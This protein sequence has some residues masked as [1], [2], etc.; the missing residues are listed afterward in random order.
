[1]ETGLFKRVGIVAKP[2][3]PEARDVL[4]QLITWLKAKDREVVLDV[5]TAALAGAEETGIAKADLPRM[6]DLVVVLGG[7]GTLLSVARLV[8]SGEVPILGVNLGGLGFLTEITLDELYPILGLVL[9]GKYRGSRRMLL[10]VSVQRGGESIAEHVVL[11][12]AVMTKG[13][14]AR[15]VDLAVFVEQEYVTTYRAD[16]LIVCTPTGS[17]AYGLSAG[18]PI[19]FPSMRAIILVPICPHTLTD[20][21]LVLPEEVRVQVALESQDEDVYLTLD[22][23]VGFPLRYRDLVEVRRADREITLIVSPKKSYYEILRSKLK[24]GE[25]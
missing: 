3:R 19:L 24:W 23:Q 22:G 10:Q 6:A 13:A 8:E 18:G 5:E 7:D 9:A 15:I 11:N 16:G 14:L 4:Q 2:H 21:P 20:R 17:T 1:M 12:D 25:R